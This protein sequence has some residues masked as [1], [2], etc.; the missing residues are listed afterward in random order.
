[1]W[2]QEVEMASLTLDLA[3]PATDPDPGVAGTVPVEI[4]RHPV[5]LPAAG[6][7]TALAANDGSGLAVET[8]SDGGAPMLLRVDGETGEPTELPLALE[9]TAGVPYGL[10][11]GGGEVLL[12]EHV[13]GDRMWRL[14]VESG[15]VDLLAGPPGAGSAGIFSGAVVGGT[16][17]WIDA[18]TAEP[19]VRT[20]D[21]SAG[22]EGEVPWPDDALAW[23]SDA[24]AARTRLAADGDT[25][26]IGTA[27]GL[28]LHDLAAGT[29]RIAEGPAATLLLW[30]LTG[31]SG[32][33]WVAYTPIV[34]W[35]FADQST[36]TLLVYDEVADAWLLPDDPCGTA[37]V[38]ALPVLVSDGA[39]GQMWDHGS[40]GPWTDPT[41]FSKLTVE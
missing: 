18:A 20:W 1:V 28:A 15:E 6:Y 13:A 24:N 7:S 37:A 4:V 23:L 27:R 41:Y 39:N 34:P 11:T 3:L 30:G 22:V 32:G 26:A 19:V 14:D 9:A 25:V 16:I 10:V 12:L 17:W 36:P 5:T 2:K 21:P 35:L 33:R 38:D 8:P 29:W 31:A 40:E